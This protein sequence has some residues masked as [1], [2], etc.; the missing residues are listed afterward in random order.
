MEVKKLDQYLKERLCKDHYEQ[1]LYAVQLMSHVTKIYDLDPR[2]AIMAALLHLVSRQMEPEQIVEYV[3]RHN[4]KLVERVP[5]HHPVIYY[6]TGPASA[7][8]AIEE[9]DERSDDVYRGIREH[10]LL[11][12]DPS[13]LA[14]CLHVASV[15][16]ASD[17]NN[18]RTAVLMC[19]FMGGRLDVA[20][21]A[22]KKRDVFTLRK[23]DSPP[24]TRISNPDFRKSVS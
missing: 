5:E 7:W 18:A 22:L 15:L 8:F 11:F 23:T 6:L 19:D 13:P 20:L 2:D 17:Q 1:S 3:A 16:V 4:P 9:L 12:E 21:N 14:Q 24:M 10:T